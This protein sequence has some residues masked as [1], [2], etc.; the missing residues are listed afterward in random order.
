MYT[1]T[2]GFCC[3]FA[4]CRG[5]K[6]IW[7]VYYVNAIVGHLY[8]GAIGKYIHYMYSPLNMTVIQFQQ[9]V[10]SVYFSLLGYLISIIIKLIL[11][12]SCV[13]WEFKKASITANEHEKYICIHW[14]IKWYF[15]RYH[16]E[17]T[18]KM[19]MCRK[20]RMSLAWESF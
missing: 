6:I 5:K 13:E 11:G 17:I 18:T 16:L 10:R 19:V 15:F 8:I 14:K 20:S 2:V 4:S 12:A 3:R 1:T 9:N 7:L